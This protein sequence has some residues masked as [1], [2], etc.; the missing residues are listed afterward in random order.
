M[1]FISKLK[2]SKWEM[3]SRISVFVLVILSVTLGVIQARSIEG[4]AESM[5]YG[6]ETKEVKKEIV[7][8]ES[9]S[10]SESSTSPS[11]LSI[12]FESSDE[13]EGNE[14]E[15]E[16]F[17]VIDTESDESNDGADISSENEDC[18]V[19]DEESHEIYDTA[20]DNGDNVSDSESKTR[21]PLF[22][23]RKVNT[24]DVVEAENNKLIA[25]RIK[26][27]LV[28]VKPPPEK[29]TLPDLKY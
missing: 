25:D 11:I 1:L 7:K 2:P 15:E 19:L 5:I 17:C 13:K 16:D 28:T 21:Q 4:G 14:E 10:K 8:D 26:S 29:W 9:N 18:F 23:P 6:H 24:N 27:K 22:L 3:D 12:P 20:S